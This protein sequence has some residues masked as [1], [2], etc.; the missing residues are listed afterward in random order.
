MPA[1]R[2][3]INWAADTCADPHIVF[4]VG[5]TV[6]RFDPSMD[7]GLLMVTGGVFPSISQ[8]RKHGFQGPIP[9]GYVDFRMNGI[10][11]YIYN[12]EHDWALLDPEDPTQYGPF[13]YVSPLTERVMMSWL[14]KNGRKVF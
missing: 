1:N 14:I 6:T 2:R 11:I 8:A 12:P 9:F 3:E 5:D 13:I 4:E 7:Y 10:D